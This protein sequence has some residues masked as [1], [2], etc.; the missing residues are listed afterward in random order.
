MWLSCE[1]TWAQFPNLQMDCGFPDMYSLY[2]NVYSEGL[3]SLGWHFL[4]ES[5]SFP[6]GKEKHISLGSKHSALLGQQQS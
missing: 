1:F 6:T 5:P 4:K 3:A 2:D